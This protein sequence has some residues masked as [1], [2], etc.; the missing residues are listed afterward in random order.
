LAV[1]SLAGLS[2][3]ILFNPDKVPLTCTGTPAPPQGPLQAIAGA[4]DTLAFEWPLDVPPPD[5]GYRLCYGLD[6]TVSAGCH[7]VGGEACDASTCTVSL[8]GADSGFAYN[9]RVFA[10]LSTR[11]GCHHL[12]DAT[13][14]PTVSATPINGTFEDNEGMTVI[15]DCDAGFIADGGTLV[16]VGQAQG[17]TNCISAAAMGDDAWSD[18][19]FDFELR[20]VGNTLAGVTF[21]YASDNAGPRFAAIVTS[22]TG[23]LESMAITR[24][25]GAATNNTD[26]PVATAIAPVSEGVWQSMRVSIQGSW[27]SIAIAPL[28]TPPVEVLRWHNLNTDSNTVY[29]GRLGVALASVLGQPAYAELRNLRVRTGVE[30]PDGGPTSAIW[31]FSGTH[32]LD[33]LR[34]VAGNPM[35]AKLGSCPPY[36]AGCPD[37]AP[38]AGSACLE[39]NATG[40]TQ[41]AASFDLPVGIDPAQSWRLR[42][43][44]AGAAGDIPSNPRI[45]RTTVG[46]FGNPP[47]LSMQGNGWISAD[48]QAFSSVDLGAKVRPGEWNAFELD[49]HP[50]GTYSVT[51]NG[52]VAASAQTIPSPPTIDPH[53]GALIL[54]GSDLLG[55][56][57]H[58]YY[59]D[60]SVSQP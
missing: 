15:T 47:V 12:S 41:A 20:M 14:S 23:S 1:S 54:G 60:L 44:F 4:G 35:N 16:M 56:S 25:D 28:G 42:F 51:W 26:I 19:T 38:D 59:T 58:G 2:C 43:K 50:N 22:A 52:N 40:L 6:N 37:C 31:D 24:R 36:D 45:L 13:L 10:Q 48:V 33:N 49:F 57:V 7:D 18:A 46:D 55:S 27:V 17:L 30:I 32:A 39:L 21:R 11:D 8:N 29:E 53:L 3:T 34:V 5:A 9:Q